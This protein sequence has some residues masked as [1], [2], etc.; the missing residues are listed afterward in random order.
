MEIKR[1]EITVLLQRI[2]GKDLAFCSNS[3]NWQKKK[4][5]YFRIV[6]VSWLYMANETVAQVFCINSVMKLTNFFGLAFLTFSH[7]F[8]YDFGY[9]FM[10][11]FFLICKNIFSL[12][13]TYYNYTCQLSYYDIMLTST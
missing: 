12:S 13:I 9:L 6:L 8:V 7:L 11:K 3:N 5:P 1:V 4:K 10:L 2:K